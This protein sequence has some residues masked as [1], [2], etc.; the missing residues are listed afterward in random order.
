MNKFN[1]GDMVYFLK[2]SRGELKPTIEC[3][4]VVEIA[5]RT[6]SKSKIYRMKNSNRILTEEQLYSKFKDASDAA[7]I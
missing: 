1:V 5:A 2:H 3:D 4:C 7:K 6:K